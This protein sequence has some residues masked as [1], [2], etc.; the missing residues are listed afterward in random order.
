MIEYSRLLDITI[1]YI[2]YNISKVFLQSTAHTC[3]NSEN[4]FDKLISITKCKE[5]HK[6]YSKYISKENF[7][8][9]EKEINIIN[10]FVG[11]EE[12]KELVIKYL[13]LF[14]NDPE[15][16]ETLHKSILIIGK[17]A[18]GKTVISECLA[19]IFGL[20]TNSV[21]KSIYIYSEFVCEYDFS[22]KIY[23]I[24][25]MDNLGYAYDTNTPLFIGG[26][27]IL[28]DTKYHILVATCEL[29]YYEKTFS[30]NFSKIPEKFVH[31][32]YLNEYTDN[33]LF[34][35]YRKEIEQKSIKFPE[36]FESIKELFLT[37]KKK[38]RINSRFAVKL[39]INTIE[40]YYLRTFD[41][42]NNNNIL[43]DDDIKLACTKIKINKINR[44]ILY[45]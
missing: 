20:L 45:N 25:N 2:T 23:Q 33:Q 35:I 16:F 42:K 36:D 28:L 5:C 12:I 31:I 17:S 43:T 38:S 26:L 21:P 6:K 41:N 40:I 11:I 34:D 15:S 29:D 44:N 4:K 13:F 10:Q 19:R 30:Q 3:L 27:N 8:S 7:E 22:R 1:S 32:V 39:A 18:T 37:N 14:F 24:D 9:L